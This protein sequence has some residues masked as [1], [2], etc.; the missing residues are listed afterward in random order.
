MVK[1]GSLPS[2]PAQL[3]LLDHLMEREAQFNAHDFNWKMPVYIC[4]GE[5][6][7]LIP[8]S[9]CNAIIERYNLPKERVHFFANAA[10]AANVEYP[11]EFVEYVKTIM[12]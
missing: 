8:V 12:K 7:V 5:F 2:R 9:T 6:D 1:Y 10:H 11:N 4:W 3:Q